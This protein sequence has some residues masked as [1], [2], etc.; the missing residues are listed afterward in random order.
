MPC[1]YI[2]DPLYNASITLGACNKVYRRN[3]WWRHQMEIFVALLA[4]CE[5]NPPV[6][7]GFLSRRPVTQSFDVFFDLRL[8]NG[9]ANNRDAGE[10]RR[11]RAHYGVTELPSLMVAD[12]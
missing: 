12:K 1:I 6:T 5:G 10:F 11:H 7:G 9:W 8:K 4:L 3:P 2:L